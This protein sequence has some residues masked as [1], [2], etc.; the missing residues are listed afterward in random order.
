MLVSSTTTRS[1]G[2]RLVRSWRKRLAEP[3]SPAEQAVQGGRLESG[4]RR[5]GRRGELVARCRELLG[6]GLG[7]CGPPPCRSVRPGAM[8]GNGVSAACASSACSATTRAMVVVLPVPGPPAR[9]A[10]R[11]RTATSAA[12]RWRPGASNSWSSLSASAASS[13]DGCCASAARGGR[14]RPGAHRA[15]SGRGRAGSLRA[16]AAR[17]RR[18]AGCRARR[19][20]STAGSGQGKRRGVDRGRRH[21]PPPGRRSSRGRRTCGRCAERGLPGRRRGAPRR[22]RPPASRASPRRRARRHWRRCRR[23]RTAASAAG[24]RSGRR[25]SKGSVP[26]ITLIRRTPR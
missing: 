1:C 25:P 18:S 22:P 19:P 10:S 6:D 24:A 7:Q 13:T 12:S 23:A 9:I 8:C 2:R 11:W 21:R 3:G 15:S 16:P 5:M 20:A 26:G 4:E 14:R 17:H